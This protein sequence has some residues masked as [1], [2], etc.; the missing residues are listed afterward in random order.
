MR[1]SLSVQMPLLPICVR[2]FATSI[3]HTGISR[4]GNDVEV[5]FATTEERDRANDLLR[6]TK[7]DL[8]PALPGLAA[9]LAV[10]GYSVNESVII[11]NCVRE[12]FRAMRRTDSMEVVNSAITA[13]ISRT[14][15]N[16]T[17]M[18]CMTLSILFFGGR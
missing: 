2:S 18:L 10:S 5:S 17:S 3:R 1:R 13:T 14:V 7:P 16:Q 15:I 12:H 6:S 11:F 8:L 9:E 4:I